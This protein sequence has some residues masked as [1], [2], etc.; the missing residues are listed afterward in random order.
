MSTRHTPLI[1]YQAAAQRVRLA[2]EACTH[3]DYDHGPDAGLDC[4][5]EYRDALKER[6]AARA[7]IARAEGQ[8]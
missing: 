1:R 4:C 5:Y 7:A 8:S 6:K 3:W 2:R